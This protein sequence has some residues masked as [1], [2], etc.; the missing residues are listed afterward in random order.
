MIRG[1]TLEQGSIGV[2]HGTT[3]SLN[4]RILDNEISTAAPSGGPGSIS[5]RDP[6]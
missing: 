5:H 3:G 4:V 1:I 6:G 2:G